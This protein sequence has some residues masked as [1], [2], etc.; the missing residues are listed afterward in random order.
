M[1]E[2]RKIKFKKYMVE[3]KG[4]HYDILIPPDTEQLW[5]I[6]YGNKHWGTNWD[7]NRKGLE[8]LLYSSAVLGFNP[9]D[10][11]IYFPIRGNIVP[12]IYKK[13]N[14]FPGEGSTT[15]DD[16][17]LIFTT[18]QAQLKRSEWTE[19]K[20]SLEYK[21]AESYVFCYD[22]ER[23]N[24]YFHKICDKWEYSSDR[25]KE[26]AI[27]TMQDT[28][29]FYV[30]SRRIFQCIYLSIDEF[31]Q[32][33]LEEEFLQ[34]EF[35][36]FQYVDMNDAYFPYR[37]KKQVMHYVEC[38]FNDI[39]LEK[40]KALEAK[41][42]Y[43]IEWVSDSEWI[44]GKE[45]KWM[46]VK[47]LYR[48]T[49][50]RIDDNGCLSVDIVYMN[51]PEYKAAELLEHDKKGN[52]ISRTVRYNCPNGRTEQKED[53]EYFYEDERV[54]KAV[55]RC[56]EWSINGRKAYYRKS[57]LLSSKIIERTY[58]YDENGALE[59]TEDSITEEIKGNIHLYQEYS[60]YEKHKKNTGDRGGIPLSE[61]TAIKE[62]FRKSEKEGR[63]ILLYQCTDLDFCEY[64]H[65]T[66]RV[67]TEL[68]YR[69]G[70]R[71]HPKKKTTTFVYES[72][73]GKLMKEITEDFALLNDYRDIDERHSICVTYRVQ[74][75][76]EIDSDDS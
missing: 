44:S 8:A 29:L 28:T 32:N 66:K 75:Q 42:Q 6:N 56:E 20:K 52:I 21:K 19:I 70:S 57:A 2:K 15:V 31:L 13:R 63:D 30:L 76:D 27:E 39:D 54:E 41:K 60:H 65:V 33:N 16:C 49:D 50:S 4:H 38:G 7:G 5:I 74:K 55:F 71:K 46:I 67:Q 61:I 69:K 58:F 40:K 35:L 14:A 48:I 43:E 72:Y 62:T 22:K 24:Q 11:V 73:G 26:F 34:N 1:G 59:R 37:K 3:F 18:H 64:S 17:D 47:N 12:E 53:S 68:F 9:A 25:K 36:P 45:E 23:C 51:E 10:K